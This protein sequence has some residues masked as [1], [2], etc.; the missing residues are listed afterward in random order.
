MKGSIIAVSEEGVYLCIGTADG[1]TPG[2]VLAVVHVTRQPGRS[3]K[4]PPRFAREYVGKV[5]IDEVVD[6]HFARATVVKGEAHEGDIVE[7][8][9]K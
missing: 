2:Q 9:A 1:A 7:L 3:P 8:E 4:A 6:E 5:R